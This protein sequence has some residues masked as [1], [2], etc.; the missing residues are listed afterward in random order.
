[1]D[2]AMGEQERMCGQGMAGRRMHDQDIVE[3]RQKDAG[4]GMRAGVFYHVAMYLRLSREDDEENIHS[5]FGQHD[6]L[7]GK[8]AESDS[9]RSQREMIRS[10]L[11][12]QEDMA[13]YD[14][15]VDSGY[16]GVNFDRPEF[17]RMMQ[18][19]EAGHVN[20]VIVKDLSR[21]GR[22]YIEAGR[23]IQK[24]FPAFSVR[25]IALTDQYDSLTAD[26][27]DRQLMVP[28][29]NFV[30]DAYARDISG[31]V[32][33]HQKI[34]RERGDFIGAFATYGYR[35]S[36]KNR[37][38]LVPDP[39]AAG[40]VRRIFAWKLQGCSNLAIAGHL[41]ECG[42]LSPMEHKKLH[43]ERLQTAF[44]GG[45]M[46]KWSAVAVKR[47]LEN[48]MYLGTMVQGK[49]E[50]I[51]YK[52]KKSVRKPMESWV[53]VQGTHPPI[54]SRE[55]FQRAQGLLGVAARAGR[56]HRYAGLLFCGDC[57]APMAR[58][59]CHRR[60]GE[61]VFFVCATK[62]KG[63]GCSRH[64]IS[65]KEIDGFVEMALRQQMRLCH[66]AGGGAQKEGQAALRESEAM[67]M[68]EELS[69]LRR[70]REKYRAMEAELSE[71][72]IGRSAGDAAGRAS[73][74]GAGRSAWDIAVR[75]LTEEERESYR[76]QY[77]RRCQELDEALRRQES[78]RGEFWDN[79]GA[80]WGASP[81]RL[82]LLT[83]IRRIFVHE[84]K[85]VCVEFWHGDVPCLP[86]AA[87]A[88]G[89]EG[90]CGQNMEERGDAP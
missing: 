19:I 11:R 31:K 88:N 89:K 26:D 43:G 86:D 56:G 29:K 57:M 44:G 27:N 81:D 49:E 42:I 84:G 83:S 24:T 73:Q 53:R 45:G 41:T 4:A 8:K 2:R 63:K 34:R 59:V 9:I 13:L 33:S 70:E 25:F 46:A 32:R 54:V 69:S 64:A 66:S 90:H 51:S 28:V 65:Q 50:K 37:N 12:G 52:V 14:A 78:S 55:N 22:D 17:R 21:L 75:M 15:Y 39:Y 62:N 85:R 38:V 10:F 5:A 61:C 67:A 3:W 68:E 36:D 74:D 82:A 20:C 77:G 7:C 30:N 60:D 16:S 72:L 80:A 35:K 1:M 76:E 71:G 79:H 23:L 18:D 48:E 87:D 47:I 40:V 6:A 58:R